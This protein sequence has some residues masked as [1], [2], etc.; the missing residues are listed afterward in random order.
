MDHRKRIIPV[1]ILVLLALGGYYLYSTNRLPFVSTASTFAD[2][3]SGFIEGEEI[4]IAAEVGGR[5]EIVVV[6]EGA[7]VIK[8]QEL[9]RLERATL[10]AQIAQA[11][12]ALGTAQAQLAQV[13]AGARAEDIRQAEAALAQTVAQ[14]DGAKRAFE[15]ASA[16][17][18]T[19]QE[20]D[21]RIA[22]ADAQLKAAK[23]QIEIAQANAITA[24][25]RVD[26]VGGVDQVRVEGKALVNAWWAAEAALQ[27]A[28][29]NYNGAQKT[30]ELLNNMKAQPLTL[31]PQVDAA[32][33]QYESAVAAVSIA[34]ARLDATKAGPTKEQVNVAEAA[35]KQAEAALGVLQ[36]QS[37]KMTL[38]SPV[39]G[40][41]TRRVA[42]SGEI[43]AP[44]AALL[45]IANLET[46][47]LTIYVP[48]TQIG[49]IKIGDTVLIQVD[50]FPG[51]VF[52]G[53]VIF[54][55]SQAEFTPRNVQ[56]KT[57]RVNTVF[58]VKV[59]IPNPQM[60]LKPGMP[61]DAAL[62]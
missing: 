61:A 36:V 16:V 29:A 48:E 39:D 9:V 19:P 10:D 31:N 59:Q 8:G 30:L 27:A 21:V 3:V 52:Q 32:K 55:A 54:I 2:S 14:R 15:N 46:V 7:S 50:S 1:V 4:S 44:N 38:K 62:K 45:T 35:V 37:S 5:I 53:K 17:R 24:R 42:H 13:K 43:A 60:E 18:D 28:Q 11:Q 22:M 12:A 58:A 6:E 49:Q 23:F 34:Q 51:K 26:A 40:I 47:K 57:E 33:A 25:T 20:L 56:T 41:V